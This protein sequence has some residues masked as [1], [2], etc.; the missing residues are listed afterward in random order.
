MSAQVSVTHI[1]CRYAAPLLGLLL[2][3]ACSAAS[4]PN[5]G[6]SA[7]GVANFSTLLQTAPPLNLTLLSTNAYDPEGQRY[8]LS[9]EA[10]ALFLSVK[11]PA[12][13]TTSQVAEMQGMLFTNPIDLSQGASGLASGD[14]QPSTDS[15]ENTMS[16]KLT[17]NVENSQD[18]L[19]KTYALLVLTKVK[20]DNGKAVPYINQHAVTLYNQS[21]ALAASNYIRLDQLI[22]E[23]SGPA[24]VQIKTPLNLAQLQ[25]E[26]GTSRYSFR[27]YD[28]ANLSYPSS[29]CASTSGNSVACSLALTGATPFEMVS[30]RV[31]LLIHY[32]N[33]TQELP[34]KLYDVT[35]L[36]Y[37]ASLDTT[38]L[39]NS[40][41]QSVS[42]LRG[43]ISHAAAAFVQSGG[44]WVTLTTNSEAIDVVPILDT[45]TSHRLWVAWKL[46]LKEAIERKRFKSDW[47]RT[48]E[49]R[50]N[51]GVALSVAVS[52]TFFREYA[53]ES[54]ALSFL[55]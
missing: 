40:D 53:V 20:Q 50:D 46:D 16:C 4:T 43:F 10:K 51:V 23:A 49:S 37:W 26:W 9:P 44:V 52:Q 13:Q 25:K 5:T 18:L 2:A 15:A 38:S 8:Q 54:Y 36:E 35:W 19:G 11:L 48:L 24:D 21:A 41:P 27:V 14:C 31:A 29:G 32:G 28:E 47:N 22:I 17:L 12:E 1:K 42:E 3:Q 39:Y 34:L 45:S 33:K 7:N 30:A 55:E 6:S